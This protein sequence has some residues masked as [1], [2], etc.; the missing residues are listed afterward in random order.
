MHSHCLRSSRDRALVQGAAR[1]SGKKKP[2]GM[3]AGFG[4]RSSA[5]CVPLYCVSYM[6]MGACT[7]R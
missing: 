4:K 5:K 6:Y 2:L 7:G 3:I 1:E